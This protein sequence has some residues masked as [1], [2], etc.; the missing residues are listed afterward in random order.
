MPPDRCCHSI[1]GSAQEY[2]LLEESLAKFSLS[3]FIKDTYH[4]TVYNSIKLK[5]AEDLFIRISLNYVTGRLQRSLSCVQCFFLSFRKMSL[6]RPVKTYMSLCKTHACMFLHVLRK[7]RTCFRVE[8]P[9]LEFGESQRS[10]P[11]GGT[12]RERGQL[13]AQVRAEWSWLQAQARWGPGTTGSQATVSRDV[14]QGW[15]L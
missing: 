1:G 13:S 3:K 9:K 2:T 10:G 11:P 12:R 4:R 8:K 5:T 14:G 6:L 7:R 15:W